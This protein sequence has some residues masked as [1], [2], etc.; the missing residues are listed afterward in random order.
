MLFGHARLPGESDAGTIFQFSNDEIQTTDNNRVLRA[1][2]GWAAHRSFFVID[3]LMS[4]TITTSFGPLE[5]ATY[6]HGQKCE[7]GVELIFA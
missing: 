7:L 5:A 1:L 3:P 2:L 6:L 4:T